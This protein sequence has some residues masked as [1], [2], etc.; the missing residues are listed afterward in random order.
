MS[1]TE[2][3]AMARKAYDA[4]NRQAF[5]E[6]IQIADPNVEVV[7]VGWNVTHQGHAGLR[8]FMQGWKTMD[9]NC[10]VETLSQMAGD[11]GVTNENIFHATHVGVL[12]PPTGDIPPTGKT[13]TVQFCEVWRFKNGK[14]TSI[15]SYADGVTILTQLGVLSPPE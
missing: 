9:P 8:D 2:N 6:V 3:A 5:D 12:R 14:L 11:E 10:R 4:F 1:A 13:V 15:H 7:N